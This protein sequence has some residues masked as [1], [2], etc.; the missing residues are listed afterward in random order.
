M[1][2]RESIYKVYA[3]KEGHVIKYHLAESEAEVAKLGKVLASYTPKQYSLNEQFIH[4]LNDLKAR[5]V[6]QKK[7]KLSS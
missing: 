5:D 2:K 3:V 6:T 1:K 7:T 4:K